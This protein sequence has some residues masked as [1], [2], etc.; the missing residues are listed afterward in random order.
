MIDARPFPKSWCKMEESELRRWFGKLL[1]EVLLLQRLAA[2]DEVPASRVYGLMHGFESAIKAEVPLPVTEDEQDKVEQ[3]LEDIE[4]KKQKS[5]GLSLKDRMRDDDVDEGVAHRVMEHA[6]AAGRFVKE[7]KK[8][9][10]HEPARSPERDWRGQ[11]I[12]MEL[13]DVSGET[14]KK[15]NAVWGPAIPRIGEFVTPMAG[16]RM[17]VVDV[18]HLIVML[19]KSEG[20]PFPCLA[21]H[22]YLQP[23]EDEG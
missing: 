13:I 20:Q 9:L 22:I 4:Y 2:V 17:R 15:L 21:P 16:S 5:D 19:S 10:G 8:A 14:H 6:A 7:V 3:M 11:M 1:A 18:E 23:I 12:Y